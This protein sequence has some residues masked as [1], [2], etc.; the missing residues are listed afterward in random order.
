MVEIAEVVAVDFVV[1]AVEAVVPAELVVVEDH[2]VPTVVTSHK[3]QM[4]L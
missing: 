1:A 4:D 3:N 2:L